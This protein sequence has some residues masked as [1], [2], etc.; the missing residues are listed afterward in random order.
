MGL[1]ALSK[2]GLRHRLLVWSLRI[3]GRNQMNRWILGSGLGIVDRTADRPQQRHRKN[4]ARSRGQNESYA[5]RA[6]PADMMRT[7]CSCE[8][9]VDLGWS[10]MLCSL[11]KTSQSL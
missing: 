10:T 6:P 8:C 3:L 7:K 2:I 9:T 11:A 4:Q 1:G 5:L